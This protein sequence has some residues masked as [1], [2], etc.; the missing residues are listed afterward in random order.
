[1]AKVA[2]EQ[3]HGPAALERSKGSNYKAS[4]GGAKKQ[5]NSNVHLIAV[6]LFGAFASCRQ[7]S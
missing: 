3:E 7:A 4:N 6:L 1:V 5:N 2:L